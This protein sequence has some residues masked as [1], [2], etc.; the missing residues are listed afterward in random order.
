MNVQFPYGPYFMDPFFS[1][2][3]QSHQPQSGFQDFPNFYTQNIPQ[4]HFQE[5][6][7]QYSEPSL[8][9][10]SFSS[11]SEVPNLK[12]GK[13][14]SHREDR[15]LLQAV[16]AHGAKNW[17]LIASKIE[18]RTFSQ[19]SQRWRRLQPHKSRTPWTKW[20]DLAV[21]E[22]VRKFGCNWTLIANKIEGRT[23]KQIRERYINKL[24]PNINRLKFSKEEDELIIKRWKEIG[25]KWQQ[26]S[27][28]FQGR[29]ENMI[30]NRFY[31]H[32]KKKHAL[33]SNSLPSNNELSIDATGIEAESI[34]ETECTP[35]SA[36]EKLVK[37]N[38]L[39]SFFD[40]ASN[41]NDD[42]DMRIAK[43]NYE[44]LKKKKEMLESTLLSINEK[45]VNYEKRDRM[46]EQ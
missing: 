33:N 5:P 3:F 42:D 23:G 20:E 45:I 27:K 32:L 30:K 24:D 4:L 13:A 2:S 1:R 12:R 26:I 36:A 11:E 21:L 9:S 37:E 18:G 25:P 46:A 34:M 43:E 15:L 19:C 22:M 41:N 40:F 17:R 8:L 14:W 31:S 38:Q 10:E 6:V 39:F 29:S 35:R 28:E 44:Y 16:Q 7:Q